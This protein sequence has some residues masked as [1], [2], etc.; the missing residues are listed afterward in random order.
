[1]TLYVSPMDQE[2]S[3]AAVEA[4]IEADGLLFEA[5][6]REAGILIDDD[7]AA[8]LKADIMEQLL[9]AT[10]EALQVPLVDVWTYRHRIRW[11]TFV[12]DAPRPFPTFVSLDRGQPVRIN[13]TKP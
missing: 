6:G 11:M 10:A 13:Q 8:N 2:L 9:T 7:A 1:M 12:D 5:I 4:S 3:W